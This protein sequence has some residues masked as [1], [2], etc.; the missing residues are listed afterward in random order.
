MAQQKKSKQK[1]AAQQQAM[2]AAAAPQQ[3]VLSPAA[4][5]A[6]AT[7]AGGGVGGAG[8]AMASASALQELEHKKKRLT[9]QLKDVE[10]QIFDLETRYLENCNPNA[11]ALTG[12]ATGRGSRSQ[13]GLRQPDPSD[14]GHAWLPPG[15]AA[16]APGTPF[17][18]TC[19]PPVSPHP[20]S[21]AHAVFAAARRL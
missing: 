6:A 2:T 9:T 19:L 5:A 14:D 8:S 12:E 20:H 21:H 18:Q 3:T 15:I 1:A 13:R 10:R 4:A 7:A 11:N 16:A 17:S